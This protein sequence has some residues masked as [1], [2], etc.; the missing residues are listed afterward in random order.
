LQ[1][2]N[3][4]KGRRK[5][6]EQQNEPLRQRDEQQKPLLNNLIIYH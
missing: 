4:L 2:N 1:E 5:E 6:K 3:K